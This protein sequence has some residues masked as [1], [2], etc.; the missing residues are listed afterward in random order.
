MV[1]QLSEYSALVFDCD[2]V[3]LDSNKVKTEAFR[4]A[5]L[6]YGKQA[7]DALVTYH[8]AHG[9]IS[10]YEKFRL[11]LEEI[12]PVHA[13]DVDGPGYEELIS[14]YAAAVRHGLQ[15]CAVAERLSELREHTAGAR[16]MVASG[17]DQQE[18]RELFADRGLE[19]WYDA[20]IYGSPTPK[21]KIV[22]DAVARG[23]IGLSAVL[24]GDSTYDYEVAQAHGLDFVFISG[25]SEA[26]GWQ[27]W[28]EAEDITHVSSVAE[29]LIAPRR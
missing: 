20:G 21:M 6:P 29:L 1:R 23:I 11:F 15:T 18:L 5:A 14:A 26:P 25:W 19:Q 24:L 10:R 3:I 12:V 27:E 2:G 22:G 16:W 13:P 9:G 4:E 8:V 28:V 7:A 17:G